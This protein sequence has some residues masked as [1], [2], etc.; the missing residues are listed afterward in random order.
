VGEV[1]IREQVLMT[2]TRLTDGGETVSRCWRQGNKERPGS[3]ITHLLVVHKAVQ[4]PGRLPQQWVPVAEHPQHLHVPPHVGGRP[5]PPA[6][7]GSNAHPPS[8][9]QPIHAQVV[10]RPLAAMVR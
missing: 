6:D 10:G 4:Q 3:E 5:R 9:A 7:R 1:R 8:Q 2:C